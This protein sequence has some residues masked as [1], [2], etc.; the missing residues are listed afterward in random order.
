MSKGW[1]G[2]KHYGVIAFWAAVFAA[3]VALALG[4]SS[5]AFRHSVEAVSAWAED[6]I[7][8]RPVAGALVFFLFSALSAMLAFASSVVLVPPASEV[9]GKTVT[10]LLLWAGWMSG[11]AAAFAIGTLARPLLA[12]VG[13]EQKLQKYQR[14]VS[15]RMSF[16]MVLLFCLA[17]P[18]EV[19]A[20]LFGGMHYPFIKFLAA[21]GIAEAVYAVGVV[22]AG[23]NLMQ[24]DPWPLIAAAAVLIAIAAGT[25][26]LLRVSRKRKTSP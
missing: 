9:W 20:Y 23:E 12:R 4:L 21:M 8:A 6:V 10:F 1:P 2:R 22:V 19:P 11:A 7:D 18:S 17:V 16:W 26:V 25:G 13:Y 15:R 24:A 3:V 5:P 14:F